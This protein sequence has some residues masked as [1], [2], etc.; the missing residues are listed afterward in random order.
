MSEHNKMT[1]EQPTPNEEEKLAVPQQNDSAE[2]VTET[3]PNQPKKPADKWRIYSP[4][5]VA[6][7][8][9][10]GGYFRFTNINWDEGTHLHPD[11]RFLTMVGSTIQTGSISDYFKTSESLLNPHNHYRGDGSQE[12]PDY[13]YGNVPIN[14]TRW[15]AE[16]LSDYCG[17]SAKALDAVAESGTEIDP[18]RCLNEN[19]QKIHFIGYDGVHLVGRFISGLLDVIAIFFVYKIGKN[20]YNR[21]IGWM[22]ALMMACATLP[23]QQSHFFT[24]DHW[25]SW[26]AT[27]AIYAAVKASKSNRVWW[28]ILFGI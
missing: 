8:L 25:A 1:Q 26:S 27:I 10:L 19:G 9:L 13:V 16:K 12:F 17:T 7:I 28:Y 22:A 24:A 5:I 6:L 3:T 18:E 20:L 4:L 11:E 23:I 15:L 21:P 14:S 2:I